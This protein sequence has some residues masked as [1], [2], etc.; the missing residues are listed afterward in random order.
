MTEENN[1][2]T[3]YV[4]FKYN[5]HLEDLRYKSLLLK[6]DF[7]NNIDLVDA[8]YPIENNDIHYIYFKNK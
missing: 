6:D 2:I 4:C 3:I 7:E 1:N 5:Y 8:S